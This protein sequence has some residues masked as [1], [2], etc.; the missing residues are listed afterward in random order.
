MLALDMMAV[1]LKEV[2][3]RGAVGKRDK[4][5]ECG[6]PL[7]STRYLST[8]LQ[9]DKNEFQESGDPA[10]HLGCVFG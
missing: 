6:F 3:K 4:R 7:S 5:T 2:I 9:R 1:C 10:V 8:N